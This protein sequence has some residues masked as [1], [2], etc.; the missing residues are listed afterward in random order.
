MKTKTDEL[1]AVGSR[2][3]RFF[4]W[5]VLMFGACVALTIIIGGLALVGWA[6]VEDWPFSCYGVVAAFATMA[7]MV[8]IM[9]LFLWASRVVANKS[10]TQPQPTPL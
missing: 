9:L 5:A 4:A 1:R 6:F 8:P 2:L 3:V 7:A 10:N